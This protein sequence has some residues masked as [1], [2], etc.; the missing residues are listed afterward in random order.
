MDRRI[1][2][3]TMDLAANESSRIAVVRE[4]QV[5]IRKPVNSS[6]KLMQVN[7]SLTQKRVKNLHISKEPVKAFEFV[8]V[9]GE[10]AI[11]RK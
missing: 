8:K 7:K 1:I 10:K 9:R 4:E 3:R 6:R 2:N 11:L 5:I